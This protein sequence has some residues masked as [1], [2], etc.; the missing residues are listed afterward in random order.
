LFGK[1]DRA[2]VFFGLYFPSSPNEGYKMALLA[3]LYKTADFAK[4]IYASPIF[5]VK[6]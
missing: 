5:S 2:S 4:S 1:N 3:L 6:D